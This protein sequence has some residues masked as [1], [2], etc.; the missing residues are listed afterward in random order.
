MYTAW[1]S[2]NGRIMVNGK[3]WAEDVEKRSVRLCSWVQTA[4]NDWFRSVRHVKS[5]YPPK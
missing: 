3:H 1:T 5:Q 2:V 4:L